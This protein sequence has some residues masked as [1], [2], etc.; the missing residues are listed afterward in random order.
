MENLTVGMDPDCD[1]QESIDNGVEEEEEN[2][3]VGASSMYV[4]KN[5]NL[6]SQMAA[7]WVL[8]AIRCLCSKSVISVIS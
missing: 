1:A 7:V 2:V 8:H 4:C 5:S 3:V 6:Y